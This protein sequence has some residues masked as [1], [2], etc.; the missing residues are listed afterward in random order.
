MIVDQQ[1]DIGEVRLAGELVEKNTDE[2]G[3]IDGQ[4]QPPRVFPNTPIHSAPEAELDQVPSYHTADTRCATRHPMSSLRKQGPITT[5]LNFEKR[6]S[7]CLAQSRTSAAVGPCF[8]RDDM[9]MV[10]ATK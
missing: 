2:D 3:D 1:V 9:A 8:R 5:D 6:C 4:H 7:T 10:Q